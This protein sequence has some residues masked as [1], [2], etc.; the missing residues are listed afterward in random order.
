MKGGLKMLGTAPE[1]E[2]EASQT[3]AGDPDKG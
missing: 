1:Y 2:F 3:L